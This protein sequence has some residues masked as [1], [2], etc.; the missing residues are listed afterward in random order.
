MHLTR[1]Y[2][3]A[4]V[5]GIFWMLFY[6]TATGLSS[7]PTTNI[8]DEN[9]ISPQTT[10]TRWSG[11][12]FNP[13]YDSAL[14][15]HLEK[16]IGI[17]DY[18]NVIVMV[19]PTFMG[20]NVAKNII[21]ALGGAVYYEYHLIPG[22]VAHIPIQALEQL[23][24]SAVVLRICENSIFTLPQETLTPT[25]AQTATNWWKAAIG[26]NAT[27][28]N[29]LNG[30][31]TRIAILDTGLGYVPSSGIGVT[32]P[33]DLA[34]QVEMTQG[35]AS[36][37]SSGNPAD[38]QPTDV[39]DWQG[40]G[41]HVAGITAG[42]GAASNGFYAGIAPGAKLFIGKV[43]NDSGSGDLTDIIRGMEWAVDNNATVISMSLGISTLGCV[44]P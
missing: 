5:S 13:K 36:Q 1:W 22:I 2:K 44:R 3:I 42:T 24:K 20:E 18:L 11:Q 34:G 4:I 17:G 16:G 37:D 6:P 21:T 14:I 31:G 32:Y 39:Y 29:G 27:S 10:G 7:I 40:H 15:T 26:A 19:D 28:L 8:L 41:T 23:A 30:T 12:V 38:V 33:A 35:F 25:P 43:L 9:L